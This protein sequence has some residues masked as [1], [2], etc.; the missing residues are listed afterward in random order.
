MFAHQS[1]HVEQYLQ[2]VDKVFSEIFEAD[3]AGNLEK[4]L[5]GKPATA[6]F[7]RLA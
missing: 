7:K 1:H 2:S 5:R 4:R 3:Q 6:G